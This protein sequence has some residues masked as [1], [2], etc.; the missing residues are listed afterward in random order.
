MRTRIS[1]PDSE[2]R[3]NRVAGVSVP[4]APLAVEGR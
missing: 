4:A 1:S 2:N 3:W